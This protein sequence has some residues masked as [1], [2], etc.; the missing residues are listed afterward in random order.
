[1]VDT[2]GFL[3]NPDTPVTLSGVEGWLPLPPSVTLSGAEGWLPLPPSVT[4][5]E[6]EG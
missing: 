2:M 6:A 3:F 5:S 4:L 1:M